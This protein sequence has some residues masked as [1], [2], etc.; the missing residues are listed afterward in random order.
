MEKHSV[1]E[2]RTFITIIAADEGGGMEI[3]MKN[4]TKYIINGI[5]NAV[6]LAGLIILAIG[7]YFLLIKAG[8]PYQ[9]P[10]A[11]LEVQYA[12]NYGIGNILSK[13]GMLLALSGGAVRLIIWLICRK[14]NNVEK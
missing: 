9:N 8:I 6:L 3:N 12:V 1:K 5:C 4:K 14:N 10:T 7:A 11:E 13:L 2:S